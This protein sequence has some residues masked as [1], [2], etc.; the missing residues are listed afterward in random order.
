MTPE[1]AKHGQFTIVRSQAYGKL[2][3]LNPESFFPCHQLRG[4][5]GGTDCIDVIV[6][7]IEREGVE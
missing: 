7:P 5:V 2:F 4:K 3:G 6:Y 1:E